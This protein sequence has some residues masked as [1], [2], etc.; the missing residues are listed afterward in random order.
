MNLVTRI[1]MVVLSATAGTALAQGAAGDYRIKTDFRTPDNGQWGA[2]ESVGNADF[3]IQ[4]R[5][6]QVYYGGVLRQDEFKFSVQIDF[7]DISGF[8]S[9][10]AGSPYNTNYDVY[11]GDDFVGRVFMSTSDAGLAELTYD[12]RHPD[13]PDLPIPVGFPS[14][15]AV[16]EVVS[17]FF[18]APQLPAI[19]DPLPSGT[20]IFSAPLEERFS[21][22]D[23]NQDGDVDELDFALFVPRYDPANISGLHVGPLAGDFTGDNMSNLADYDMMVANWTGNDDPPAAPIACVNT[24]TP[25]SP[26][27]TCS[28]TSAQF[29][30][31]VTGTSAFTYQ[32][33]RNGLPIGLAS[34]STARSATLTINIV[35]AANAGN[36]TCTISSTCAFFT[37]APAALTVPAVCCDSIDFNHD[38]S[39]FDPQDIEAYLSVFSEGP[40]IPATATCGDIDFNNDTSVFDPCDIDSFLTMYSEGP[41]TACGQ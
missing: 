29:T 6:M 40:C 15:V 33:S 39:S 32:W 28:G 41:C 1:A 27:T 38:S 17:V 11:I 12:S 19:G 2:N 35:S 10:F 9:N 37:T 22:G 7:R 26:V 5:F 3:R 8:A 13:F 30:A 4:S 16:D 24:F 18:A 21:R 14:P 34:N 31:S 25:P 20:P 23:V 36:Y